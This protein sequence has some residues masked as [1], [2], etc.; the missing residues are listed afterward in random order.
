MKPHLEM[1]HGQE[2]AI[3]RLLGVIE[4]APSNRRLALYLWAWRHFVI[5]S[6]YLDG[7][8]NAWIERGD[9]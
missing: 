7:D 3:R 2:V 6:L 4:W 9:E 1:F 8:P 5:V